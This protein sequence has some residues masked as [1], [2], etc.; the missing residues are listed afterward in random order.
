MEQ[1][2][3][4]LLLDFGQNMGQSRIKI[5]LFFHWIKKKN[6]KSQ[7]QIRQYVEMLIISNLDIAVLGYMI[8]A[9]LLKSII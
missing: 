2:F 3:E 8:I 6:I 9:Q 7:I 1:D 4:A 5:V